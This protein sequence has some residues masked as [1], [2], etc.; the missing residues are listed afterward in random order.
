MRS[1]RFTTTWLTFVGVSLVGLALCTTSYFVSKNILI[2]NFDGDL[3]L[4]FQNIASVARTWPDGDFYVDIDFDVAT[5]FNKGGSRNF[6]VWNESGDEIIDQSPMLEEE[7]RRLDYPPK[8]ALDTPYFFDLEDHYPARAVFQ[9]IDTQWG[10]VEEQPDLVVDE[11]TKS[12]RVQLLVV[13]ERTSLDRSLTHLRNW[14]LLIAA[15]IP[16]VTFVIV[17]IT[18]GQGLSPLRKL[19]RQVNAIQS[20]TEKLDPTALWPAEIS[21]VVD[22]LNGLLHRLELTLIRERRFN[23]DVAHELRSPLAELRLATDIALR[24]QNSHERLLTAAHQANDLSHSMADLVNS[25]L[26]LARFQTGGAKPEIESIDLSPIYERQ[27]Q[28]ILHAAGAR[29]L[30]VVMHKP[31]GLIF[32]SDR[33]LFSRILSILFSNAVAYAPA[34]SIVKLMLIRNASGF[35]ILSV[36]RA[37]DLAQDDLDKL[38]QPFWRKGESRE[39]RDHFGIGLA[40]VKEAAICLNLVVSAELDSDQQLSIIISSKN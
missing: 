7:D 32:D 8:S 33:G 27:C 11:K 4:E 3:L 20:S 2:E 39:Q 18:I 25:M 38:F 14:M 21:L 31:G 26:L 13:R 10:W 29:N 16:I 23:A 37:P 35:R 40:I 24:S 5:Q 15:I 30:I 19:A 17:Y 12:M 34:G 28:T 1:I 6:Q 9:L 36:N 22:M